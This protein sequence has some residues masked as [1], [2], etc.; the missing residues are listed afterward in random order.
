MIP[1]GAKREFLN[2]C[3]NGDPGICRFGALLGMT[4]D[5]I[6]IQWLQGREDSPGILLS[7]SRDLAALA[8]ELSGNSGQL[9]ATPADMWQAGLWADQVRPADAPTLAQQLARGP[10]ELVRQLSGTDREADAADLRAIA[11][12][13]KKGWFQDATGRLTVLLAR[14]LGQA[15]PPKE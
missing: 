3:R 7:L 10:A 5:H 6:A 1:D 4:A 9:P 8:G 13:L 2:G 15:W 11:E 12:H 14:H